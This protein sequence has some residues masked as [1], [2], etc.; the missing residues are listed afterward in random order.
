MTVSII[1][2][3]RNNGQFLART[4]ESCFAQSYHD[5]EVVYVDD[6]S[7]DDSVKI[8]K[9]CFNLVP[10]WHTALVECSK[11]VGVCEARNMGASLARGEYLLF[12]DGEDVL[13]E[14]Y[15]V[16]MVKT[17]QA[18]PKAPFAYGTAQAFGNSDQHWEVPVKWHGEIW[19]MNWAN[20]SCLRRAKAFWDA[21]GWSDDMTTMWD[22]SLALRMAR[23][24]EPVACTAARLYYRQWEGSWS[25][26]MNEIESPK[27]LQEIRVKEAKMVTVCVYGGRRLDLFPKWLDSVALSLRLLSKWKANHSHKPKEKE[28]HE[29]VILDTSPEQTC[30]IELVNKYPYL[31][32]TKIE[33]LRPFTWSDE[34]ERR[35]KVANFMAEAMNRI[36]ALTAEQD[37]VW[38]IE[39]DIIVPLRT[40]SRLFEVLTSG[41]TQMPNAVA[42][43]YQNRHQR[44]FLVGGYQDIGDVKWPGMSKDTAPYPIDWTGTGCLMY[45]RNRCPTEWYSHTNCMVQHS[46]RPVAAHDWRWGLDIK[47]AGGQI[48][49]VPD[50]RCEHDPEASVCIKS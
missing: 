16:S 8:A 27:L 32:A 15:V 17:L 19:R 37:I 13:D 24:G 50:I 9:E 4:L 40:A 2:T 42:G 18:H 30:P 35:D 25:H 43:H 41:W 47:K 11:H 5:I 3:A 29:I 31:T 39:D 49:M 45:W 33:H 10:S 1:V 7:I 34:M 46:D 26:C 48:L 12:L 38:C 14:A 6:C 23:F 44:E 36:T 21:G 20:T 22:W 28:Y